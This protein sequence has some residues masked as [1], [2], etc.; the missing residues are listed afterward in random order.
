MLLPSP[1]T[2]RTLLSSLLVG[3]ASL[4]GAQNSSKQ[5]GKVVVCGE[6]V[7]VTRCPNN[8][9]VCR[10]IDAKLVVGNGDRS[11]PNWAQVPD[12]TVLWCQVCH[13]LF[14]EKS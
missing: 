5:G 13:A 9:E 12:Y 14:A 6:G 10:E 4:A 7:G 1:F 3:L 2:R 8:H 11:N